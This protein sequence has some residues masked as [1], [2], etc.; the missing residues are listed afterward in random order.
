MRLKIQDRAPNLEGRLDLHF[1]LNTH[2]RTRFDG[3]WP[4]AVD[5]FRAIGIDGGETIPGIVSI[6]TLSGIH[7]SF[8]GFA[9]R[10]EVILAGAEIRDSEFTAIVSN[11]RTR[12]WLRSAPAVGE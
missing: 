4:R 10:L 6:G 11:D 7:H 3:N 2:F 9:H 8:T 1:E 12:P 5:I